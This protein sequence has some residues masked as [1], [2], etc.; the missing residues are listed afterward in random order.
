MNLLGFLTE[1]EGWAVF[2]KSDTSRKLY[3]TGIRAA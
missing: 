2:P 1:G 3:P